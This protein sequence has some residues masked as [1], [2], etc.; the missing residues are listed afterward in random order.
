MTFLNSSYLD[1]LLSDS[2]LEEKIVIME[3]DFEIEDSEKMNAKQIISAGL[4]Y[5]LSI[6]IEITWNILYIFLYL[7][8]LCHLEAFTFR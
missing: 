7:E 1:N 2:V 3:T 8:V 6:Y 4:R 5:K